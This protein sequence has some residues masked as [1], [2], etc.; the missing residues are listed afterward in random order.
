MGFW[1]WDRNIDRTVR[2]QLRAGETMQ[3]AFYARSG[4]EDVLS[5]DS[6]LRF[7]YG[8]GYLLVFTDQRLIVAR[9]TAFRMNLV[10]IAFEEPIRDVEVSAWERGVLEGPVTIRLKGADRVLHLYV[11]VWYRNDVTR[12][13]EY[14]LLRGRS[15]ADGFLHQDEVG[16]TR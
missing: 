16:T 5:S 14:V 6:P 3:G 9:I 8:K 2:P 12:M 10:E 15:E 1:L 7:V 13:R 4:G 11:R